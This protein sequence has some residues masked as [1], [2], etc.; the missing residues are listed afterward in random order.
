MKSTCIGAALFPHPPI[1]LPEI[2]QD[3]LDKIKATV[4][5]VSHASQLII[6]QHPETIIIMSP[7]NYIFSDGAAIFTEPTLCGNLGKFG[8]PELSMSLNTDMTL[9]NEI[10]YETN[11]TLPL[12]QLNQKTGATVMV[13]LFPLIRVP[14]SLCIICKKQAFKV[15][16]FYFHLV[17]IIII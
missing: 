15:P 7:H 4:Q 5:A 1:M 10:I 8:F 9:A 12:H 17:F 6:E 2:G 14:L 13:I 3:E 11:K 16:S